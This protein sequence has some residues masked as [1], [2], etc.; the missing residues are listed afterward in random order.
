MPDG[1]SQEFPPQSLDP[2]QFIGESQKPPEAWQ[3][4]VPSSQQPLAQSEAWVQRPQIGS[5]LPVEP[6]DPEV[7]APDEPVVPLDPVIP[8][9][10]VVPVLPP[11]K[12]SQKSSDPLCTQQPS[13]LAVQRLLPVHAR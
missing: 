12:P 5:P 9:E 3:I 7:L 13:W 1:M 2:W 11:A 8:L 10:P 6:L 4:P